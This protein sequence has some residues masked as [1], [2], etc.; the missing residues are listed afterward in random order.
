MPFT[1]TKDTEFEDILKTNKRLIRATVKT[2]ERTRT[3]VFIKL[4]EKAESEYEFQRR[5]SLTLQE[6][7]NLIENSAHKRSQFTEEETTKPFQ[8]KNNNSDKIQK[9]FLRQTQAT[10][11]VEAMHER[12]QNYFKQ[13]QKQFKIQIVEEKPTLSNTKVYALCV[14]FDS[15]VSSL[16]INY[17]QVMIGTTIFQQETLKQNQF[18]LR[19]VFLQL[20]NSNFRL[21]NFAG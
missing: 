3:Y 12:S 11:M 1:S 19:L 6:F 16:V 2:H 8:A 17:Y 20:S 10:K 4:F 13:F 14:R 5:V 7:E 9:I 21:R 18:F 15:E